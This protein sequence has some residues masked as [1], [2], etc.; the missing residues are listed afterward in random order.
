MSGLQAHVVVD[1]PRF[2][3]DVALDVVAGETVAVMGPSGAGKSTLLGALAGL[4]PLDDG[5][6]EVAGRTVEQVSAPRVRLEP[7]RR[8]VVLLG[9]D[10]RLFPHLSARENVA[11][12][13][14]VAGTPA[15]QARADADAWLDR[16]G[17][18]GLGSRMP[19]ELSGGEQQRV[20]IARAL[21]ASPQVVLLDEPLV[22][23]DPVT[24][25]EIRGMLREQL[26]GVT[27]VAVTHDAGDA[28]ALAERLF[29]IEAGAVV[30]RGPV[31]QVLGA[32]ASAFV[33]SVADMNRMPGLSVRGGWTDSAGRVLMSADAASTALA[34][35]DGVAL[36][37][38]FRPG[39]VR[40]ADGS[41][42]NAWSADVVRVEPTVAGARVF[43][44]AAVVDV[45]DGAASW[46]PGETVW[47]RVEPSH[48]RF[49]P[50]A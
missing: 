6:I 4:V 27:T 23:L 7:M 41:G 24:A 40:I 12:G 21:A 37:A 20:A 14:R 11:F 25:S 1:R 29:V 32:P 44:S 19:R 50:M 8:G 36:A 31:R 22:A 33:A 48:V 15:S 35:A 9:Q 13:P 16:V 49:V 28:V 46:A 5:E 42:A 38:V 26:A 10:P 39:D 17:L 45:A 30:Q 47:L 2:R 34:A 43:T 18:G 3:V